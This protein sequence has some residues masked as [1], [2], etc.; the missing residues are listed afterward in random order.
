MTEPHDPEHREQRLPAARPVEKGDLLELDQ[1]ASSAAYD[2]VPAQQGGGDRA[3]RFWSPR[4][5]PAAVLALVTL[6]GAGLLLYDVAA[7]RAGRPAMRWRRVLAGELAERPLDNVWV[8]TGAMAALVIGLWLL[9]LAVTPGLRDLLPMRRDRPGIRAGLDRTAAA[10]VLRDRA[11]EVSGVQS[12]RVRMGRSRAG[13]R[14][15]SHFRELDDVRADLDTVL[16]TAIRELG[17]ARP[18]SLSVQV[19]RPAKKG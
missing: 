2:P 1:S 8:L 19:R 11:G 15:V 4:R 10:L 17:L 9:V 5:I 12:V 7:V 3:G 18:P 14:A 13:V 16:A 6:G